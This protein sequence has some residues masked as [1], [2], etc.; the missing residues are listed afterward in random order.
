LSTAFILTNAICLV[1]SSWFVGRVGYK[2]SYLIGSFIVA[3][4]C[5]FSIFAPNYPILLLFRVLAGMGVSL[6]M[7]T[8]L[9]IITRIFPKEKR[10]LVIG[11]NTTMVYIGLTIGPFLGGLLTDAF[12]WKSLFIVMFPIIIVSGILVFIFQK[13]EFHEPTSKFDL[14]GAFLYALATFLLM[15]GLSTITELWGAILAIIGFV[16]LIFFIIYE[17]RKEYPVLHVKLFIKNKRFARSSFAALLN[18]ASAYGVVY[19]VSLYLQSVGEMTST[20][21]GLIL[22]FQPLIQAIITPIAGKLSDHMDPKILVT[23]G[24]SLTVVGL[25]TL[26]C[27]GFF[28]TAVFWLITLSQIIIGTGSAF[29]AAPNTLAIMNSVSKDEYSVASGIVSVVRQYGM[30]ISTA[31]CMASISIFIGGTAFLEPSVYQGFTHAFQVAMLICAVLGIIGIFFS[32][33]RGPIMAG[34]EEE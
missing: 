8:G 9:A 26:S 12:G 20:Q 24:M 2:K 29:F 18:Y 28:S 21:A 25:V 27:V 5:I 31:I 19:M 6:F 16:V 13:I 4:A 14:F 30:L 3:F 15:Y 7:V 1:P 11:I 32:W 22:L 34:D 23:L 10:G 33:F 17:Q